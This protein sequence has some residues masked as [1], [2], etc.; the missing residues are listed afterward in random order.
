[1]TGMA[2]DFAN[3]GVEVPLDPELD[4]VPVPG[5][6]QGLPDPETSPDQFNAVTAALLGDD[7]E[8][9]IEGPPDGTARLMA[10]YIDDDGNRWTDI[11]VR[12][13]RGRDEELLE[14][15]FVSGD[16]GRYIDAICKAGVTQL[17]PL[18]DTKELHKALDSLLIGDRDLIVMHVRRMAYGDTQRLN[19]KCPFCEERF[20]VD[21][22]YSV[23]VPLKQF[24]VDDRNQRL[25][26][27][28]LPSGSSCEIRLVDGKAQ[29]L[30]YTP[31]NMKKTEAELNTA[32]L[33]ELLVSIDGKPVRGTGPVLDMRM[34]DRQFLLTWL[35]ERQPGP[36]YEDVKQ[37]CAAC[38]REFPLVMTLRDMFRDD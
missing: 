1:M 3:G 15:A 28:Q 12:E 29:K 38:A 17:G 32:L 18:E 19:V 5:R 35:I 21:Y 7:E 31:E 25:F 20:Q 10:G 37:E 22:S 16:M 8:V 24:D 6:E 26:D 2:L 23:D 30:V 27:V 34:R 36:R 14:R 9:H 11:V 33:A 13:L 4:R